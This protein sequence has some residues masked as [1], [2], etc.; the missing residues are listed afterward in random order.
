[1][2]STTN[3]IKTGDSKNFS[4]TRKC[5]LLYP[6]TDVY[7]WKPLLIN[8]LCLY[9]EPEKITKHKI[10]FDVMKAFL[11]PQCDEICSHRI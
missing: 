9:L 6:F 7:F 10:Q 8:I 11:S 5:K 4:S 3:L 1:M 2:F